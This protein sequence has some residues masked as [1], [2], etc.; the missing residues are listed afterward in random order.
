MCGQTIEPSHFAFEAQSY[1]R[2]LQDILFSSRRSTD[3]PFAQFGGAT[4]SHVEPQRPRGLSELCW[5]SSLPTFFEGPEPSPSPP[6]RPAGEPSRGQ[7]NETSNPFV[8]T[9]TED[10]KETY[11]PPF[12]APQN[13]PSAMFVTGYY[14][15]FFREVRRL[16]SGSY[17]QV[18]LCH[19][20]LD[21]VYLGEY[22]VKKVPVGDDKAWLQKMLREVKIRERLHN[23][24]IV[25]YKHSW[26]E[27][28]R[29]TTTVPVIPWLFVL[30]EYCN[31][32]DLERYLE[33]AGHSRLPLEATPAAS[34]GLTPMPESHIWKL[35][36]DIANGLNHLHHSGILHRDLKPQ[37]ILLQ[38]TLDTLTGRPTTTALLSDFGT[39]ELFSERDKHMDRQGFTGTVEYTAPELLEQTETGHLREDYDEKSDVW[40][41]G[42]VL[43]VLA[44]GCVPYFET[45]PKDC[46]ARIL[47]HT[48]PRTIIPPT[49]TRSE[50]L[51]LLI[52]ALLQRDPNAR[53]SIDAVLNHKKVRYRMLDKEMLDTAGYQ[54]TYTL[55][56]HRFRATQGRAANG[57]RPTPTAVP[58]R[59][60]TTPLGL[61]TGSPTSGATTSPI[62]D[63]KG[64]QQP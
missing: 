5:W 40:S 31:G 58:S 22:A 35:F 59:V 1:F 12:R 44:Y 6:S 34:S 47:S 20:Y 26:L 62:T 57:Q 36:F 2:I 56:C 10:G 33:L 13:L 37:N 53:P 39:S 27:M 42:V 16:G 60:E 23:T 15:N 19:H 21:D 28:Y 11:R 9:T 48:D 29:S 51:R 4:S 45:D 8:E 46:R 18:Y 64:Q 63:T 55:G 25:Q 30:M 3:R 50:E 43:F 17:G 49:P 52:E 38:C 54:I 61:L 24:N 32:G 7:L 14:A 41:L